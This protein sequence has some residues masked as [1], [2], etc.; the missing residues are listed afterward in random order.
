MTKGKKGTTA[1]ALRDNLHDAL[2]LIDVKLGAIQK[3]KET[4]YRTNTDFCFQAVKTQSNI[5]KIGN[6]KDVATLLNMLAFLK[7]KR[8]AYDEVAQDMGLTTYP[9]FTWHGYT[10]DE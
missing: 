8:N 2:S 3:I 9:I 5:T 10:Y 1:V 4:N 7:P 6:T